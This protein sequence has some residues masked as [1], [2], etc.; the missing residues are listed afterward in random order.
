M[1]GVPVRQPA[2]LFSLCQ[3]LM[4]Q[5]RRLPQSTPMGVFFFFFFLSFFL[6]LPTPHACRPIQI[7]GLGRTGHIGFNE[8][9]SSRSSTTRLISLDR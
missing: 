5:P 3:H 8:R 6:S 4:P 1:D 9:G 7:L 2:R